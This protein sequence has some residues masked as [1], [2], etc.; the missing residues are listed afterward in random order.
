MSAEDLYQH[1]ARGDAHV[2]QCW[3]VTRRDG[4]SY[5][6]T[7]HDAP[8]RFD[9]QDFVASSG[10]SAASLAGSTGL[11][12]DNTE[13]VGLLHSDGIDEADIV[14]GRF[15]GAEVRNWLVRWDDVS[16]RI[17]RFRGHIGEITR[18]GGQ[19]RAELRGLA[20][21][22]NQPQGRSFLRS[23][24]AVLG[25]RDCGFDLSDPTYSVRVPVEVLRDDLVLRVSAPGYADRWFEQGRLLVETGVA[26]GLSAAIKHDHRSGSKREITL[27]AAL[28]AGLA[29]G[30]EVTL[31]AGCDKR[32]ETCRV[33]FANFANF[34][35]FPH[36]PGEDWLVSVPRSATADGGE[37][38]NS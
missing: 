8:L 9:G 1:L 32:A 3:L 23:C 36:V 38:L 34:R 13:A 10:L 33:K 25:D 19:F 5:G 29:E 22:L 20:E 6:F 24:S 35:G 11:S 16:A 15:D 37:S 26:K 31:Q 18:E 17:T 4:V 30:D 28:R 21:A 2:C 12:V 7:D 27:W 14:A